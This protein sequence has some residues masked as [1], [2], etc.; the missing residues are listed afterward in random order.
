MHQLRPWF[1][2]VQRLQGVPQPP[3]YHGEGD[4]WEHTM[5]V[6]DTAAELRRI[7]NA[8]VMAMGEK[9]VT[10]AVAGR[11]ALAFVDSDWCD[12]MTPDK[13]G[14]VHEGFARIR[15]IERTQA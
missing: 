12:G 11:M 3:R 10:P 9:V 14:M 8:N 2:E 7:T 1:T 15:E 13:A 4:V 5:A 6:L